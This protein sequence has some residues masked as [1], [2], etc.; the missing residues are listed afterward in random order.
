MTPQ[1]VG[2]FESVYLPNRTL[3]GYSSNTASTHNGSLVRIREKYRRIVQEI[4]GK[5]SG[6]YVLGGEMRRKWNRIICTGVMNH[7]QYAST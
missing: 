1:Q 6:I 4:A 3:E 7:A 2:S 5:V